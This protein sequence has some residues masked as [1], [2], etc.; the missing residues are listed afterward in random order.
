LD[1]IM[2]LISK[3]H[4]LFLTGTL[5]SLFSNFPAGMGGGTGTGACPIIAEAARAHGIL[6]VALVTLPF[7]FEGKKRQLLAEE[8]IKELE[9]GLKENL[10]SIFTFYSRRYSHCCSESKIIGFRRQAKTNL[11]K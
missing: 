8:G 6:T 7:H 5:S 1:E 2:K 9:K 11:A 4:M 3:S 10:D